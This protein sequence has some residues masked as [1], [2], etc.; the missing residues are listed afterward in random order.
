[1]SSK[2]KGTALFEGVCMCDEW[3]CFSQPKGTFENESATELVA[4]GAVD[5]TSADVSYMCEGG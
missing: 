1:M 4:K 2:S 5:C 3:S